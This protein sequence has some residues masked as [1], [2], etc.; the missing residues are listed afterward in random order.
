MYKFEYSTKWLTV[1]YEAEGVYSREIQVKTADGETRTDII[2]NK[3]AAYIQEILTET[4]TENNTTQEV[5]NKV[6]EVYYSIVI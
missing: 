5:G 4:M 3:Q 2:S 1:S 6:C